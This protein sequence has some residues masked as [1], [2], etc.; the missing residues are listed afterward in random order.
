MVQIPSGLGKF[1]CCHSLLALPWP[2]QGMW[3]ICEPGFST[4]GEASGGKRGLGL[5]DTQS[6]KQ[7]KGK[8]TRFL[9]THTRRGRPLAVHVFRPFPHPSSLIYLFPGLQD[10]KFLKTPN[11][12]LHYPRRPF[13]ILPPPYPR[14]FNCGRALPFLTSRTPFF[15][16]RPY[17]YQFQIQGRRSPGHKS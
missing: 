9:A 14:P 6:R 4:H 1:G 8:C 2:H 13:L 17:S 16:L 12:H 11:S 7:A 10:M 5:R 3:G 15:F